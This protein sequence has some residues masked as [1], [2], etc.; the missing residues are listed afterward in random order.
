MFRCFFTSTGEVIRGPPILQ[1][2]KHYV[3]LDAEYSRLRNDMSDAMM[4][5]EGT[6]AV[7][8]IDVGETDVDYTLQE[9]RLSIQLPSSM[10]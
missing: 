9:L 1:C 7:L 6:S 4:V 2:V 3:P 10:T 5:S 8:H